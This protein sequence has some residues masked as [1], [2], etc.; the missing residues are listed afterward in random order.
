M[1]KVVGE[2][3]FMDFLVVV[4]GFLVVLWVDSRH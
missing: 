1:F 2:D 4:Q 3:F